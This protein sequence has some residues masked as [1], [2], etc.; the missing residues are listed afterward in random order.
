MLMAIRFGLIYRHQ[1]ILQKIV[2]TVS[3]QTQRDAL[4]KKNY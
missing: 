4:Y 1:A 3:Y 2:Y